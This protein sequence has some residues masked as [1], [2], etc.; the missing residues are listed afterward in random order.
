MNKFLLFFSKVLNIAIIKFRRFIIINFNKNAEKNYYCPICKS[1]FYSFDPKVN[2]FKKE[3]LKNNERCPKCKSLSRHRFEYCFLEKIGLLKKAKLKV[4]HIAPEKCFSK[5]F[6]EFWNENYI[7]ADL[8]NK[9]VKIKMDVTNIPFK[10]KTFDLIL[11]NHVLEHVEN[12]GKALGEFFRILKKNE[13]LIITVPLFGQKT[14]ENSRIKSPKERLKYFG[15]KDHVRK[16]GLDIYKKIEKAGF[17]VK[18]ITPEDIMSQ[19]KIKK[20]SIGLS[21]KIFR[22]LKK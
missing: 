14:Y 21:D 18:I 7:T 12:D 4:L 3:K 16:Y 1:F 20:Y 6:E 8:N 10:D 11:C 13:N 15:Q 2:L 19:A 22:C 17:K 9:N 5:I